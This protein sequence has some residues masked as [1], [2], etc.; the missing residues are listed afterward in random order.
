MSER[1]LLIE[2]SP[3]VREVVRDF[4]RRKPYSMQVIAVPYAGPSLMKLIDEIK[5][6]YIL[7]DLSDED[8]STDGFIKELKERYPEIRVLASGVP[9]PGRPSHSERPVKYDFRKPYS[10]HLLGMLARKG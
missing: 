4:L 8:P 5:P 3:I 7:I 6:T 10:L 1:L 2:E 9:D